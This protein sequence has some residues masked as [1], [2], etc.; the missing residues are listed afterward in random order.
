[1][2]KQMKQGLQ[3]RTL[4]RSVRLESGADTRGSNGFLDD[5]AGAF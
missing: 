2:N 3:L 4:V 1:M 5:E